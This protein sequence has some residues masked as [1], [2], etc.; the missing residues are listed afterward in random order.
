M[1]GLNTIQ[2]RNLNTGQQTSCLLPDHDVKLE[3]V[4][5][6]PDRKQ[7]DV[8]TGFQHPFSLS[9]VGHR[10]Q[11][12]FDPVSANLHGRADDGHDLMH[13]GEQMSRSLELVNL[14]S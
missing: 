3:D 13:L 5:S 10:S 14:A 7:T 11:L 8:N 6:R 2:M 1:S 4:H 12:L 9:I